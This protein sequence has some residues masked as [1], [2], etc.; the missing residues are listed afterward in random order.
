[1]RKLTATQIAT[2]TA[3][4]GV[5]A[6]TVARYG[7]PALAGLAPSTA[8]SYDDDEL[9]EVIVTGSGRYDVIIY[10]VAP[11]FPGVPP[12]SSGGGGNP[13]APIAEAPSNAATSANRNA[14]RCA[15]RY[16]ME[17]DLNPN[18]TGGGQ[19]PTYRTTFVTG[20]AWGTHEGDTAQP[21]ITPTN[22]SPGPG[23]VRVLG[24][25]SPSQRISYIYTT[26]IT[27]DASQ[28]GIPMQSHLVNT[29]GHEWA[30]QWSP[31]SGDEAGAERLGD[32]TQQLFE[33]AGGM[34][35]PCFTRPPRYGNGPR[36]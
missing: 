30:H 27:Y 13:P 4:V 19:A 17:A 21:R 22:A 26:N 6:S 2:M 33:E 3:A 14:L 7:I 36:K 34:N 5:Y 11:S 25:T 24:W 8:N 1:M 29:L 23:Y 9:D 32:L 16:T 10:P 12:P 28:L 18:G 31:Y 20:W 15:T 35:A